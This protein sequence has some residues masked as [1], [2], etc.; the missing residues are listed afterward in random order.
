MGSKA[1]QKG[2]ILLVTV[3]LFSLA[4]KKSEVSQEEQAVE[5]ETPV[6]TEEQ[7]P[8]VGKLVEDFQE[9]TELLLQ[10]LGGKEL[11]LI[12]RE[13][14]LDSIA[15]V[16][17]KEQEQLIKT[18]KSLAVQRTISYIIGIIGLVLIAASLVIF[19]RKKGKAPTEV[20]EAVT[21]KKVREEK[22][23]KKLEKSQSKETSEQKKDAK[24]SAKV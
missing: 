22:S 20:K 4:C 12:R 1:I 7:E 10:R 13:A 3:L 17:R 19:S 15:Q 24:D 9:E 18:Q 14:E 2:A 8:T 21:E 5:S 16:L 6:L 23:A 11:E